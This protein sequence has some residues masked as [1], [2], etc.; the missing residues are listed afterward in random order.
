M[1]NAVV[2]GDFLTIISLSGIE[3]MDQGRM[4]CI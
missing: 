2:K 1:Q 3:Y 4:F